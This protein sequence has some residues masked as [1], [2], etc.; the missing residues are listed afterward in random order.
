MLPETNI[1]KINL[2]NFLARF[3]IGTVIHPWFSSVEETAG[4]GPGMKVVRN[5]LGNR[6]GC[7]MF[8][9]AVAITLAAASVAR[10]GTIPQLPSNAGPPRHFFLSFLGF[11]IITKYCTYGVYLFT[12]T[13]ATIN[14]VKRCE[15]VPQK[16]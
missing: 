13:K 10:A 6:I 3:A 2:V 8:C 15:Y 9:A 7:M 4:G 16:L 1:P 5:G 11:F 14:I 12:M